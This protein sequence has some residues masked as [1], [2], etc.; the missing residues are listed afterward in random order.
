[1]SGTRLLP[2]QFAEIVLQPGFYMAVCVL[3]ERLDGVQHGFTSFN[4]D[5][6]VDEILYESTSSLDSS[7]IQHELGVGVGNLDVMGVITSSSITED[8]LLAG[9]YDGATVTLFMVNP[10]NVFAGSLVMVTGYFGEITHR[11]GRFVAEFRSLSQRLSQ[12][13]GE[14][15]SP[16]CRVK[17]LGDERCKIDL[18]PFQFNRDVTA[19]VD[20]YTIRFGSDSAASGNYTYGRVVFNE[21]PNVNIAREVKRHTLDSGDALIVL[22]EP[23]PFTVSVGEEAMLEA[24]CDRAFLTCRDKF[25][26]TDN[27]R[28]EPHVPEHRMLL[29]R[30]RR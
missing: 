12:Q 29:R 8:A 26:N 19:V 23:F 5:L 14:L 16:L 22:Q 20:D 1:M 4:R 15:T 18:G 30:G 28:G 6:T 3:I 21:G 13:I 17:A 11:D 24:G 10:K 25:A 27:F 7:A 9:L 2:D